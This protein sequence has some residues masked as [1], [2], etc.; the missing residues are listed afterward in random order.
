MNQTT[1]VKLSPDLSGANVEDAGEYNRAVVLRC[2]HRQAPISRAEIARQT[3]FTKPAIA[4][5]VDRLLDEGLIIEAR[6]RHGLRGQPAIELEINPDAF[7]AIG[8][9]I[10]RDHLTI[11]AVDAVGNVRARVHHE[12]RYIL[13][14]EFMQLTA[15]AI[16]HFQRSRLIDDA[17]LAGIGLAMPDWLG[18]IAF[19][20]KPDDYGEWMEF[21]VRAALENLTPHPVFIENETNAAALAE[22]D[23]GLGAESRSFFYISVNA[24]PGGGLVLDGNG[25]RGAMG[26]SGE[27]GWLPIADPRD[28]KA[29]KVELLGEIFSLFFLYKFLGEHGIE[30]SVPQD[31]LTLD[32]RG[33]KL[34][35]QWL[36][37]MSAHLAVAVKHIGM[38]VDPDS[39]I[40]GGRLPIRIVD[41]LLRYVH[42]HLDAGDTTLPTLHRASLGEDACAIGAAA[43]PMAAALMLASADQVQR[44]RSPLKFMDRLNN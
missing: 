3:G 40:L 13:P 28:K 15:D 31:L 30:A 9:N 8:I 21:D 38:I 17:H 16:S 10:D 44:T 18:E 35:S 34:V 36:K 39:I 37:T 1:G 33:R 19:L 11:L 23:Y 26:L 32:T 12:K 7:F 14:A 5:I 42:E 25:H 6:R 43:M 2:I 22:L 24:C 27:I 20:G 29:Q 41:E 4:R